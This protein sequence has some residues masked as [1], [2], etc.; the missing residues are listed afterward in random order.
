MVLG[1]A[2]CPISCRSAAVLIQDTTKRSKRNVLD[3]NVAKKIMVKDSWYLRLPAIYLLLS[4]FF[5]LFRQLEIIIGE[6]IQLRSVVASRCQLQAKR[7]T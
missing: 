1:T 5:L 6:E 4:I 3:A 7:S 2:K